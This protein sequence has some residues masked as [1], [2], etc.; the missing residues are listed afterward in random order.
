MLI[1]RCKAWAAILELW[2]FNLQV[3]GVPV[4]GRKCKTLSSIAFIESGFLYYYLELCKIYLWE[5]VGFPPLILPILDENNHRACKKTRVGILV[6]S[7]TATICM[8][9]LSSSPKKLGCKSR[10]WKNRCMQIMCPGLCRL[11]WGWQLLHSLAIFCLLLSLP[12]AVFGDFVFCLTQVCCRTE[13]NWKTPNPQLGLELRLFWQS[14]H[15]LS[16]FYFPS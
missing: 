7:W 6:F 4:V 9:R 3:P 13:E 11:G 16:V 15:T 8:C 12:E 1:W 2:K 5:F 14:F 10:F